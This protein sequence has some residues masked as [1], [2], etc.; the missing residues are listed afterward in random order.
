MSSLAPSGGSSAWRTPSIA[1]TQPDRRPLTSVRSA[2]NSAY[3]GSAGMRHS[4]RAKTIPSGSSRLRCCRTLF[5]D[6]T[7]TVIAVFLGALAGAQDLAK[8]FRVGGRATSSE[9]LRTSPVQLR[10]ITMPSTASQ[11]RN[12]KIY[13][14]RHGVQRG[15]AAAA[16]VSWVDHRRVSGN[17][18]NNGLY[19]L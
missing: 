6:C 11:L 13:H 1:M 9:T 14:T 4:D 5:A 17:S 15:S 8:T 19:R 12:P 2:N 7:P 16:G 3:A 10:F 18:F